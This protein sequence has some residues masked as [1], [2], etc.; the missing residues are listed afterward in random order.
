M[1]GGEA[2]LQRELHALRMSYG[3]FMQEKE[4][5]QR[6]LE[7]W[8]AKILDKKDLLAELE[9]T[10]KELRKPDGQREGLIRCTAEYHAIKEAAM[11]PE[12]AEI[13]QSSSSSAPKDDG[14]KRDFE[15]SCRLADALANSAHRVEPLPP[16]EDDFEKLFRIEGDGPVEQFLAKLNAEQRLFWELQN[17]IEHTQTWDRQL[18]ADLRAAGRTKEADL[19]VATTGHPS[20]RE[21][22]YRPLL[23]LRMHDNLNV[24]Y[25]EPACSN[26]SLLTLACQRGFDNV[27]SELVRRGADVHYVSE[28]KVSALIAA[29][30]R[31]SRECVRLLLENGADPN[32]DVAGHCA[33]L[34]A[35]GVKAK[36]EQTSP[37]VEAT[38]TPARAAAF[39]VKGTSLVPLLLEFDAHPDVVAS[40]G[41]TALALLAEKGEV[42]SCKALLQARANPDLRNGLGRTASEMAMKGGHTELIALLR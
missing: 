23:W 33:L 12:P 36:S 13:E 42:S 9:K 25:V 11:Q 15:L 24:S 27:A 30:S 7:E 14:A 8:D 17:P 6:E 16:G 32:Q 2:Q 38:P 19:L 29:C 1:A 41:T 39:F 21:M 20:L 40:D 37:E 4:R 22:Q 26:T 10:A 18:C 31:G 28:S 5:L 35:A 34:V 3:E